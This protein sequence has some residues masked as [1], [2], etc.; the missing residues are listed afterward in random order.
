MNSPFSPA[1]LAAIKL[2]LPKQRG[3]YYG[4]KWHEPKSGRTIDTPNPATGESLGKVADCGTDDI[5]AAVKAAKA[6]LQGMEAR[7]A[8]RARQDAQGGRPRAARECRRARDDRLRR[9]RQSDRRDDHGRH[10]RGGADRVLRRPRHRDEGRVDPDGAGPAE[11]LG[12]RAAR[13]GRPHRAVQPSL[14][15][16]RRQGRGAARR[17]QHRHHEAAGAG[18]AVVAASGRADR[19]P[20]A[21]RRVQRRARR[22]GGGR[23]AREPSGRRQDRADRQRA[24]RQGGDARGGRHAEGRAAR[25]RRQ[26]RADRLS[27]RRPGC[28]RGRPHRRHELHVVRPVLRLDQPR[29]HPREDLRLRC[30]RR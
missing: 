28:G 20:A 18:A 25:T 19:R 6:R 5:D 9:L 13:R 29:L 12:A 1:S 2:N 10:H 27:R 11:L 23:R 16:H 8:A 30:W 14:H 21:A 26:E 22:Q 15:V 24:D 4:G 7:A 3:A 17:R